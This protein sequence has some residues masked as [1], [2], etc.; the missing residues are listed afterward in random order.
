MAAVPAG[1]QCSGTPASECIAACDALAG[2]HL[3]PNVKHRA[4]PIAPIAS[5]LET[6]CERGGTQTTHSHLAWTIRPYA[7]RWGGSRHMLRLALCRRLTCQHPA[8]LP[9]QG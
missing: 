7:S 9:A 1:L 3:P 5:S 4:I 6:K 8:R 2:P